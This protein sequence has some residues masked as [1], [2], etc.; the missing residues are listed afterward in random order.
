[1]LGLNSAHGSR[2]P[3]FIVVPARARGVVLAALAQCLLG[4]CGGDAGGLGRDR[5]AVER[6]PPAVALKVC[7]WGSREP[8][9][10]FVTPNGSE[11]ELGELGAIM[12]PNVGKG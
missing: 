7:E 8:C 11:V 3:M 10:S 2:P 6:D 1:M 12:D 9:K 5:D 4:A